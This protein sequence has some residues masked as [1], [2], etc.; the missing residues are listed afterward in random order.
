MV[1]ASCSV[2]KLNPSCSIWLV[3]AARD[4]KVYTK[5]LLQSY[6][7]WLLLQF[8][9]IQY[10]KKLLINF[11]LFPFCI[12]QGIVLSFL[13]SCTWCVL[14]SFL[15]LAFICS[16]TCVLLQLVPTVINN[17]CGHKIYKTN[18]NGCQGGLCV[19]ASF[20]NHIQNTLHAFWYITE[21]EHA[22]HLCLMAQEHPCTHA[23]FMILVVI[24]WMQ[25]LT[26]HLVHKVLQVDLGRKVTSVGGSQS[27]GT[28]MIFQTLQSYN[29]S[30]GWW[31]SLKPIIQLWMT[32]FYL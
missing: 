31:Q 27:T 28:I 18:S 1:N 13:G 19:A 25:P 10:S 3:S 6:A 4:W 17:E 8:C 5:C 14:W 9:I 7:Q 2:V 26:L 15:T 30:S 11:Q 22:K 29:H 21:D 16:L 23:P 20:Q 32:L 24:R 12:V